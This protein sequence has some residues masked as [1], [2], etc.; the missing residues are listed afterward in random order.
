MIV[1]KFLVV[2]ILLIIEYAVKILLILPFLSLLFIYCIIAFLIDTKTDIRDLETLHN[3]EKI[4][5]RRI[6]RDNARK[7]KCLDK[8]FDYWAKPLSLK[9]L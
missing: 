3:D 8:L 4:E 5:M 1:L 7:K 2:L 9:L 6:D